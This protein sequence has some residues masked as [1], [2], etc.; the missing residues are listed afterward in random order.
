MM[1]D[2]DWNAI[3]ARKSR[4]TDNPVGPALD[5]PA[6]DGELEVR[7]TVA[8]RVELGPIQKGANV[9]ALDLVAGLWADPLALNGDFLENGT[10]AYLVGGI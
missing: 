3:K 6:A 5:H 1:R 4:V 10:C 7:V 9:V 8:R 2:H